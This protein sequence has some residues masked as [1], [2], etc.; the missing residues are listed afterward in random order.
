MH[1]SPLLTQD[2]D[3][4]SAPLSVLLCE[5]SAAVFLSLLVHSL[6]TFDPGILYRLVTHPLSAG[7]TAVFVSVN[8]VV[9]VVVLVVNVAALVVAFVVVAFVVAFVSLLVV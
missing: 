2:K 7:E 4:T 3:S 9:A 8:L 5:A 6:S 1:N